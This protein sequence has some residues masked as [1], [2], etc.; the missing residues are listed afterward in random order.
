MIDEEATEKAST[1]TEEQVPLKGRG[2][3]R[4]AW[5]LNRMVSTSQSPEQN[6]NRFF[7]I[8]SLTEP[9]ADDSLNKSLNKSSPAE[10]EESKSLI[11]D[12]AQIKKEFE[13]FVPVVREIGK[14]IKEG[15]LREKTN[16]T[17]EKN[18]KV[19]KN[20]K[21]EKNETTFT[22]KVSINKLDDKKSTIYR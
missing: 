3:F 2:C 21:A 10:N 11:M 5:L 6:S 1:P 20:E 22:H 17:A 13:E 19:E 16:E 7:S 8:L 18:E 4:I 9:V 15:G 12:I 14:F